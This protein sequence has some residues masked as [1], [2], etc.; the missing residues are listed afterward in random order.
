MSRAAAQVAFGF[1]VLACALVIGCA[2]PGEPSAR[3]PVIPT[4]ITDLTARQ[5]GSAVV[6]TFSLPYEST[7]HESLAEA[8]TIEVY[9]A[10]LPPGAAPGRKTAWRLVY[11]IPSERVDSYVNADRVEFR[12]PLIPDNLGQTAGS[13][14][15]YLVRTR[16]V[17]S[18]CRAFVERAIGSRHCSE[19]GRLSCVPC[20]DR[21]WRRIHATGS[22]ASEAKIAAHDARIILFA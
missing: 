20:G 11:T 22:I 13:P 5:S 10:A 1:C 21:T 2:A 7:D 9:R 12:D 3:H 15:T 17:K 6:L 4:A 16:A 19:D 18:R 14:L 8:P